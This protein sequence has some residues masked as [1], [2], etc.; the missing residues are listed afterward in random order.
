MSR[1]LIRNAAVVS[2]DPAVGTIPAGDILWMHR[3]V[4]ASQ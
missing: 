2:V 1:L 4:W 3:I